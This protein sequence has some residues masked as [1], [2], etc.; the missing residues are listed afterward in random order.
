MGEHELVETVTDR[1]FA[2]I[3]FV[4]LYGQP[5]S[6]QESSLATKEAIWLGVDDARPK[7]LHG[8]A[9]RL[10]ID[11]QASFGW[12][13]YPLPPEVECI[14]RMHLTRAQVAQLLPVLERFVRTG[15]VSDG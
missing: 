2:L 4:D 13:D 7:V 9:K 5:C 12:V 1:G 14:T 6:L 3:R 10:G 15:E 8:D 11:T